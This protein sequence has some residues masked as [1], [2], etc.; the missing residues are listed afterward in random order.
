MGSIRGDKYFLREQFLN[1]KKLKIDLMILKL[2]IPLKKPFRSS[3]KMFFTKFICLPLLNTFHEKKMSIPSPL[4][5]YTFFHLDF[6]VELVEE[7]GTNT[8]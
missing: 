2:L 1:K 4:P 7:G 6:F 3:Q 5:T 8:F